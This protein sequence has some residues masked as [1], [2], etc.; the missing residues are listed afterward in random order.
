[1]KSRSSKIIITF[2]FVIIILALWGTV[3]AAEQYATKLQIDYPT[4]NQTSRT[5]LLVQGWVMSED[6]DNIVEIYINNAKVIAN[7]TRVARA[8]VLKAIPGYGG[9]ATNP[10]PGYKETIDMTGYK[11]GTYTV[12][13][14]V[15]SS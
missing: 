7:A 14:K 5:S 12:K 10:N 15:I 3:Q 1:M 13:V 9:S 6:K 4:Q 2:V 11:D 8:D